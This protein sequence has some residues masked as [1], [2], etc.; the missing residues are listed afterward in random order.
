MLSQRN[1]KQT[2]MI[3]LKEN[4]G[5]P[6]NILLM[7]AII[8]GLTV[9]NCYYNQPLLELIRHDI[10]I[11]E[12]SANLITVITQIGYAL[13]LFFLIPLGDMFSRKRLILFNMSIAAV[14][15]IV[16]AVAQNVWMLWGA[17][18]LIGA[19]SV[20]PQFFIPIAGQFSAP[21]N[22]SRNMGFVL[23]G[24]LTGILTSRV[25]SGYIGE[26]LG[27][28]EMFIIAAFV[29]LTCMGVMLLM[30]PEMKRNYEGTYRGLMSTMAEII[31]LHP[32]VRIYSIRAAFGFG[33]MMAIWSCLAFH[34]AQPPF[35]AGSDMVGMLGLCGIMG[36]VAASGIGKQVPK[37]GIRKFSLFGAGMQI[38]AWG[39]ALLFGDT[40]AGLI[41]AIILVDIGLQCQQL[42]N[43]SGCL[44]EITHASNRAN[45]IF[46]TTYFIG[47]SLGTFCAGYLWNRA[48]WLGVCIVGI[49]FAFMSLA[50]TLSNRK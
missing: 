28:R 7:M 22:K 2:Q 3:Q 32:S 10:G 30:M 15:A 18:L 31:I 19:C 48:N 41:A 1:K 46:M 39:I 23:S 5:I 12:Q 4:Q 38:M 36:A 42:S 35:R 8:A 9:A 33:S 43:Q 45:T 25:I 34:L 20:I 49:T 11:T 21:K 24:L 16:M 50:I 40:Y 14:M 44:Q 29:M 47:G 37:F 26:W 13:G 6:R 27:W 17:S